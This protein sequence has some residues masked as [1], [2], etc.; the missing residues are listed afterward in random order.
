MNCDCCG[1]DISYE[2]VYD[3]KTGKYYCIACAKIKEKPKDDY[4]IDD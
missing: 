2:Y 4:I 1:K 3:Q